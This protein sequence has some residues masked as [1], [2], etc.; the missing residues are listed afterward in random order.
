[1]RAGAFFITA[2]GLA[3]VSH[4]MARDLTAFELIQAG[5]P[6]VGIQS[7]GKVLQIRSEKSIAGLTPEVWHVLY[8][9]PSAVMKSVEVK[10][11]GGKESDVS[12]PVHPFQ[13]PYHERDILDQS[14]LRVDSDEALRKARSQPLLKNLELKATQMTLDRSK[15]GPVWKIRLW[16][17]KLSHP[18]KQ[19]DIGTVILSAADGSIIKNDLRPGKA[20]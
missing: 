10:F 1:M 9:D 11:T 15:R 3:M 5:N 12:H 19:V 20:D 7:K 16:A 17:A 4:V 8:Y 18:D 6:Y 13:M 14:K 2:L